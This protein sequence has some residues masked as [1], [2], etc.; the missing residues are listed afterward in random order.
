MN[1]Q[2][3][4]AVCEAAAECRARTCGQCQVDTREVCTEAPSRNA[5]F[6]RLATPEL[7]AALLREHE[8]VDEHMEPHPL[9]ITGPIDAAHAEVA[10]IMEAM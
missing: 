7:V 10:R 9:G 4:I 8:A 5:R 6:S 3:L 1:T 2:D